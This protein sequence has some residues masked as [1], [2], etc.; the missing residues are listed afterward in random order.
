VWAANLKGLFLFPCMPLSMEFVS[1]KSQP[2]IIGLVATVTLLVAHVVCKAK[3]P[4]YFRWLFEIQ[5]S[6]T[7]YQ[8]R[9]P[10]TQTS[11]LDASNLNKIILFFE[12]VGAIKIKTS[13]VSSLIET[14]FKTNF[15]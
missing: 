3:K 5:E 6:L 7:A 11:P 13:I 10:F 12:S 4:C 1:K 8:I 14:I 15:S 2:S 9:H